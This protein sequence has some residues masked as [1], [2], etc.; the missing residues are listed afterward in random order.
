MVIALLE[1][2]PEIEKRKAMLEILSFVEGHVGSKPECLG[3]GVFEAAGGSPRVLYVEQWKSAKDL[4]AHLRSRLY[5]QVLNAVEL[6][7]EEPRIS[8][9]E[10]SQTESIELIRQLRSQ[11]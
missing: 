1:L 9:H 3:C 4:H 6:A 11:A 2:I 5:L 10:V 8:F 7:S